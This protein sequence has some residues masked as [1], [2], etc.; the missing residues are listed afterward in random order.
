MKRVGFT[1]VELAIIV[2]V[3]ATLAAISIFGYGSWKRG[4]ADKTVQHDLLEASNGLETYRNF[5]N[6]Y[7]SNIAG[8]GF[9]ASPS[10]ALK[11]MTNSQQIPVYQSLTPDQNAQLLLNS[12]NAYM[13]VTDG[14]TTYNTAC[15]FAGINLHISGTQSSNVLLH[16]PTLQL[17][18]FNLT[19]GAACNLAENNI[20]AIF[21][22]QGG[23]WPITVANKQVALPEPVLIPVDKT[24]TNYCLEGVSA[25]YS[26]VVY[27]TT[28]QNKT[29]I[30]GA[31]PLDAS[32]HYP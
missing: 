11:L 24:A 30:A 10:V 22:Q 13:P 12:C 14:V 8:T 26:D 29:P 2:V 20:L 17:S 7:P 4:A 5:Q 31:C 3:I 32:L 9:A 21:S 15:N 16:G 27:H 1:I 25:N 28:P 18:D 19:C 6:F 23:T